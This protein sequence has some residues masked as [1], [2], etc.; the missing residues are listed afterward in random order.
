[1]EN[2]SQATAYTALSD[3]Y[4]NVSRSYTTPGETDVHIN[5]SVIM[6]ASSTSDSSYQNSI[7]VK[8]GMKIWWGGTTPSGIN[9]IPFN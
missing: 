5:N 1:M 9:F 4:L 8:K 3:G 2:I 7:F 6:R